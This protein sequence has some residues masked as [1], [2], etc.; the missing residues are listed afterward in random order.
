MYTRAI[1]VEVVFCISGINK[2]VV[3]VELILRHKM[4][5]LDCASTSLSSCS[6]VLSHPFYFGLAPLF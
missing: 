4:L 1:G 3:Y 2:H 5:S 6:S